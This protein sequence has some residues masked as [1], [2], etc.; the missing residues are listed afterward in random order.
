MKNR[1]A[2]TLTE[3][4][5]VLVV[6]AIILGLVVLGINSIQKN[7]KKTYYAS[8]EESILMSAGD[9]YSYSN[10]VPLFSGE[11]VPV[12]V[13]E[14]KDK[15]FIDI[16][17]QDEDLCDIN[18][19]YVTISK[20]INNKVNYSVCLICTDYTS[21]NCESDV[22]YSLKTVATISN[23]NNLYKKDT[24]VN[25]YVTLTFK[26]LKD[27]DMVK[28]INS[29]LEEVNSCNVLKNENIYTCSIE[30]NQSGTYTPI[31][32]K[33]LEEQ[34][35]GNDIKILVDKNGPTF[36]I[37]DNNNQ[38]ITNELIELSDINQTVR[39]NVKDIIDDLSG[40]KRIRY[41]FESNDLGAKYKTVSANETSFVIEKDLTIGLWN[42]IVEITDNAGNKTVKEIKYNL[43]S[44]INKNDLNSYCKSNLVYNGLEQIL[45]ND[46]EKI[47]FNNNIGVDATTY[48]IT[49]ILNGGYEWSDGTKNDVDFTCQIN[50]KD[51]SDLE[52]QLSD[53]VFQYNG[54]E[55]KPY[56]LIMD[57]DIEL[58]SGEDY[59]VEYQNNINA[60]TATVI[61]N[62][63]GNYEGEG[64]KNF[65][66]QSEQDEIT[67]VAKVATYTGN[68]IYANTATSLSN[69]EINYTYYNGT[70]CSGNALADAPINAGNYSVKAVSQ[71][72]SSY[73]S[74]S[75]C[76]THTITKKSGNELP[77]TLSNDVYTYNGEEKK[78][79][80]TIIDGGVTLELNV[81]YTVEYQNNVNAGTATVIIN[82][83]GNYEG[84]GS[85][86]FTIEKKQD[87]ITLVAKT[88]TYTGSKIYA[89]TGTTLSNTEINYTYYN[90]ESCEGTAL[91]DAPIN[92][93]NYS[94]KAVSQGNINYLS[95]S[96]C[97]KHTITKKS[98]NGLTITLSND[99]YT[100]DGEE[101]KPTPT[102]QDGEQTLVA[103]VDYEIE[104]Q[105]N[106][107]AGTAT[108]TITYIGNYDGEGSKTFT[109]EKKQDEVNLVAKTETY[110]GS[111]IIANTATSLSNTEITYSYYN[112][113][114]C[115]GNA[116][117]DAPINAGNY[118]V[119]AVSQGNSNY[120]SG[121]VC[122]THTITKK[123]GNSLAITLSNDV[124]T[125][126][127]EE[128]KPTVT[129]IDG[130]VTLELN[131]DYTVEY[132]NNV[133]AGTATV[134]ITYIGNY[135]GEGSKTFTIEK[136]QDEITLAAK[137]ETYTGSKIIA[138][139]A[140][141]LS[142][143]EINYTYYN[144]ESCEGTALS[145]APINVGNYSVKAVSQGNIN[146]LSGSIC[147][148][149]TITKKSGNGLT[150]TLS[151][152]VYT[153]DGEEKK[154]TP[155]IQDGE[156]TLVAGVDY[157]IEYQNNVNA[158][159]ATVTITYIGNYEGEGS[160]TFTIEKSE[161]ICPV[162][163]KYEGVYDGV[164]HRITTSG[165]VG[166]T[167]EYKT[168]A[169]GSY[170][171]T[172]PSR[173]KAGTTTVYVQVKGDS[174]H[175]TKE[176]GNAKIKITKANLT[177]TVDNKE[178]TYGD[179]APT[180]TYQASGFVNG[181]TTSILGG[182][183]S[184][185]VTN[186]VGDSITVNNTT[187]VGTYIIK[188]SG[189]TA[190]NYNIEY[191]DGTL[192]VNRKG[193]L[194]PSCSQNA[195]AGSEITLFS[196]H[197]SGEYTNDELKGTNVGIYHVNLTPTGNYRWQDGNNQEGVRELSCEIIKSDTTTTLGKQD[198]TYSGNQ[199]S[200]AG[201]TSKLNSNNS[202][203]TGNYTYTYYSGTSCS[204]TPLTTAPINVGT[205]RVIATLNG[206]DNYNASSSECTELK[207]YNKKGT[208]TVTGG[209]K[210]LTYKTDG[211]NTY[212]YDGDGVVSCESS[213]PS[214]VT[215]S[216]D[217]ENHKIIVSPVAVTSSAITITVSAGAG[218][219]YS[220]AD[221]QT[222]TVTV[223]K[224]T[225][226]VTLTS[227][228]AS[229]LI[230]TGNSIEAN[231]AIV[232]LTNN[233]TYTGAITYK[234]YSGNSCSGTA[235]SNVPINVGNYMVKASIAASGNYNAASSECVSHVISK[236]NTTTTL[237]D[238]N[239]TYTGNQITA[240]GASSKL[241]S[242]NS[243]ITGGNYTYTYYQGNS[244]SGTVL[245]TAPT[246]A[247]TYRV[248]ANLNGTGNYNGSS[249]EC[250][251][252]IINKKVVGS[253]SNLSVTP[254]GTVT[255]ES[256][257]NATGYEISIDGVTYTN[258]ESGIDYLEA[259]TSE[260]G[261]RTVR[262]RG[263]N[264]DTTNYDNT[265][266]EIT[267]EVLVYTLSVNSNNTTYGTVDIGSYNVIS[268]ATYTTNNN[269][270]TIK[271]GTTI[272][273][274][275]T[276]TPSTG[277]NFSNFSSSSGTINNN[278]SIT[279][280]FNAKTYNITLNSN[281][282][283]NTPTESVTAT[284]MSSVIT[285]SNITIPIR[286]YDV[287]GFE[288]SAS[289]NS[290][291]ALVSSSNTLTSNYLFN[292]WYTDS[293]N[294][295]LILNN[296]TTPVLQ[297]NILGYTNSTS[298]WI[299]DEVATLNAQWTPSE[300]A[301]PTITKDGYTCGWT[302]TSNGTSIQYESG[303]LIT[304]ASN[305]S[306]FGICVDNIGPT[307][308]ITNSAE[309]ANY[310][311][312][313]YN[314]NASN[315]SVNG[316][317]KPTVT[318][319]DIANDISSVEYVIN[320]TTETPTSGWTTMTNNSE[321]SLQKSFG[322]YYLHIKATDSNGNISY[323]TSKKFI[324]RYRVFFRDYIN[325]TANT[326]S[327]YATPTSTSIVL[328]TPGEKTGY[329]FLGWYTSQTGGTRVGGVG[330]SYTPDKTIILYAHWKKNISN[331]T[332]YLDNNSY[333]YDGNQKTPVVTVKDGD[334]TLTLNTDY[335]VTYSNNINAGEASVVITMSNVLNTTT[336]SFY[337]G[338]ITEHFT[339]TK[340][341]PTVTISTDN[342][343]INVDEGLEV[344]ETANI[345]G[346]Y[347]HTSTGTNIVSLY[348]ESDGL[349]TANTEHKL[350]IVG[351]QNG[352]STVTVLF[353]P[354]DTTNYNTVEKTISVEVK[355]QF[356]ST[357][358]A[359]GSKSIGD[360]QE[361]INLCCYASNGIS[362]NITTPTI[363][364]EDDFDVIG[365]NDTDSNATT[366]TIDVN[367]NYTLT[368]ND[369]VFYAITRSKE[370]TRST[371]NLTFNLNGATSF[372]Y[373]GVDY[374]T[375]QTFTCQTEYAYNG[376][377]I[378]TYCIV[379][380][381]TLTRTNGTVY[382]FDEDMDSHTA[383][384]ES[385]T[386][387]NIYGD[388]TLYGI[389]SKQ[390]TLTYDSNQS[391]DY[392][393]MSVD[394]MNNVTDTKEAFNTGGVVFDIMNYVQNET[395]CRITTDKYHG[396]KILGLNS[397]TTSQNV[398]YCFGDRLYLEEDKTIH[399]VWQDMYANAVGDVGNNLRLREGAG[400]N[401]SQIASIAK[402]DPVILKSFSS[403]IW[404]SS[405]GHW[406]Y[407]VV[408]GSLTGWAAGSD[409]SNIELNNLKLNS[410]PNANSCGYT[411]SCSS[412]NKLLSI[413][414]SDVELNITSN[415]NYRK[416]SETLTILN[417][418]GPMNS[419]TSSNPSIVTATTDG[420][421][422]A[423][424]GGVA[425]NQEQTATITYNTKY[426]CSEVVNVKVKNI[427]ETPPTINMTIEG[428]GE[429]SGYQTGAVVTAT[430]NS[431][432]G[433]S[434]YNVTGGTDITT[435]DQ[436]ETSASITSTLSS[437]GNNTVV[438]S[439]TGSNGITTTISNTYKIYE[440]SQDS[441]CSCKTYNT[442]TT[443]SGACLCVRRVQ[444]QESY[445][446]NYY[447]Y[448]SCPSNTTCSNYCKQD[449]NT[450]IS[451]S[452]YSCSGTTTN[453]SC[454]VRNSCWHT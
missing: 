228:E 31:G 412:N 208:L 264:S 60:G 180:Y 173:T 350:T 390:V 24:Y 99:V 243:N 257:E 49:A 397:D 435:T 189:L 428:T 391:G 224:Y 342:A 422:T 200:V 82:Y 8:L 427:D 146:Y 377:D 104:Y 266:S 76:V 443:Y 402:G 4:I 119:K 176:C 131:V 292:G 174:N 175:T 411:Y 56:V 213:D 419:V 303:A 41:S 385:G 130:G 259:I 220:A 110:T 421:I 30:V 28:L 298:Q 238:Q 64:S 393:S 277:Y 399:A 325:D 378:P 33:D 394:N 442:Q 21:S 307:I 263:V 100:Y 272:L 331:L 305:T 197:T 343:A 374:T 414:P 118:S 148:K 413:T 132:Q 230:Y 168:S 112:G 129:I 267:T 54:E 287:S 330:D 177:I 308:R 261:T 25:N 432:T 66:I 384:Y 444:N 333:V 201:V 161:P 326:A 408:Y 85:K 293:S 198:I 295:S 429:S 440:Y 387:H 35:T 320:T 366:K 160:K 323:A 319:S 86:T 364:P 275:I 70:T 111:K 215:C 431:A 69:T 210:N 134:T 124:Y 297:P 347:S 212:S 373:L 217:T 58:V 190:S 71:G 365:W 434:S 167:L 351:E 232:T 235:L 133:N 136:K 256:G 280:N 108:V 322:I 396:Y 334:T 383:T 406:W 171:S 126:N 113:T 302:A 296:T 47:T 194:F 254:A 115:G 188:S 395:V 229:E 52:I 72:N 154:P 18:S 379:T 164:S 252:F 329:T 218:L 84:E 34:I 239:N 6:L 19:S 74:G 404:N 314:V 122:V 88:E 389:S 57:G 10:L 299:K 403:R 155:T 398:E 289:R 15:L 437:K 89:N 248:I 317:F 51:G 182:E 16:K 94:V 430:C 183:I 360:N 59:T 357:F 170:S 336:L 38:E 139:T 382:G 285:P 107:N 195:Y 410:L 120:L 98:G 356:C 186:L 291:G 75:I 73:A 271:G 157:E 163:T 26:T 202:N 367:T 39:V 121:S 45:T 288:L 409:S 135:E 436:T 400:T 363:T 354:S 424:D 279:A 339:I 125:Y 240:S 149:H 48:T 117:A 116:L 102:I 87:E 138:N 353:T 142:N 17:K 65:T 327:L 246:S 205:Y 286:S 77:I 123:S 165:E 253:P 276:A 61:I 23:T 446:K 245:A 221:N 345:A 341:T 294:G 426:G 346:T 358:V 370:S 328:R 417:Q 337:E 3:L 344:G 453:T 290:N 445:R 12:S 199:V 191:V 172:I 310:L 304:P 269:K 207:I 222:F 401:Y 348:Q 140:T 44:R 40:I 36:K 43:S 312:S 362:C 50:P 92:V 407:P 97:V 255:W 454:K 451:G 206:T 301:L 166:G 284:Y 153:Y 321:L 27:L 103:G 185:E 62:Y 192:T 449:G 79:T 29:N 193:I 315:N 380:M 359:N 42:L 1:K 234:Y 156:Q 114:T 95:G 420:V 281:E 250:T 81:D 93:G 83:I 242:N 55:K 137:T 283:T 196:G 441:S 338:E 169:T 2:F 109:I 309:T 274:T 219:N 46:S 209:N 214:K 258:A 147:V 178:M 316:T 236:S 101:K 423:V 249:S 416:V 223:G 105:N 68:K 300:V 311:E 452:R 20:D 203:I 349:I 7:A 91:S 425:L 447:G 438:A 268:G 204:G 90:G 67:L 244:C 376:S 233:E 231:Q 158:G 80:V 106:V 141:S 332:I 32:V 150:I 262:V 375:D 96:I 37:Y 405:D 247:G 418:C 152:D 265:N 433:I 448:S 273:K 216:V 184:Y 282:A 352:T 251:E 13:A 63:I 369:K 439:C 415:Q 78:P 159:T 145:D 278:L 237:E 11:S 162:M 127:G 335:T 306:L 9:Y 392:N 270:I 22:D 5:G 241:S 355:L 225:P 371:Y 187:N 368:N 361:E 143:T 151:N 226:T 313:N 372:N 388:I 450:V 211:E 386:N 14:L 53:D 144:G 260:T 324:V 128:K 179:N 381:P 181:Q 227:K 340:A 318:A